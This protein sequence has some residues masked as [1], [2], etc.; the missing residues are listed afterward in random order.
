MIDSW[1]NWKRHKAN[2]KLLIYHKMRNNATDIK[3][4]AKMLEENKVIER[5]KENKTS[6]YKIVTNKT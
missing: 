4:E 6:L 5:I 2:E 1:L 3:R